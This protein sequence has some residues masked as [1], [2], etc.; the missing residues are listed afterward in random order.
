MTDQPLSCKIEGDELVIRIGIETLAWA[1]QSERRETLFGD[2]MRLTA[3]SFK[4]GR[5]LTT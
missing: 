4:D 1:A 2:T 5:L 3:I